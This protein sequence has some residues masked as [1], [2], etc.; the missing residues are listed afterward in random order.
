MS[1]QTDQLR[2]AAQV[3]AADILAAQREDTAARTAGD[4][5]G[6]GTLT[7]YRPV[8]GWRTPGPG[9]GGGNGEGPSGN[10][11]AV[12][13]A[14]ELGSP[15]SYGGGA[16]APESIGVIRGTRQTFAPQR[17]EGQQ[18][19]EGEYSTPLRAAQAYNRAGGEGEF[20]PVEGPRLRLAADLDRKN[21]DKA[22]LAD[23]IKQG[24]FGKLLN[25]RLLR[26]Y[27]V[28]TKGEDGQETLTLPA[29]IKRL[30]MGHLPGSAEDV[31]AIVKKIAPAAGKW[32]SVGAWNDPKTGLAMRRQLLATTTD[33]EEQKRI[34]EEQVTPETL[35]WFEGRRAGK[36]PG[37]GQEGTASVG[38][39]TQGPLLKRIGQAN[40]Q[41]DEAVQA[42]KMSPGTA[43][44]KKNFV[45]PVGEVAQS[46]AETGIGAGQAINRGLR[47]VI[48]GAEKVIS[49][50]GNYL[51]FWDKE[52]NAP[53]AM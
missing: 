3:E 36:Q 12:A 22:A 7:K 21:P 51:R 50:R 47:S 31:E 48:P 34:K 41:T 33:P 26:D 11:R 4:I 30:A 29:E 37:A 8:G 44:W 46:V 35:S 49:P 42:G 38:S 23:N 43:F 25:D 16:G 15:E 19:I 6:T 39:T 5:R 40:R 1:W 32:K 28:V 52:R 18:F 10:L 53:S 27:G 2:G 45:V 13:E 14:A 20:E 24:Q 9:G 17:Q